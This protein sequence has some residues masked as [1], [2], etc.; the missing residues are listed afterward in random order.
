MGLMLLVG[1]AGC[2]LFWVLGGKTMLERYMVERMT[3]PW[4]VFEPPAHP[5]PLDASVSRIKDGVRICN[6]GTSR[7]KDVLVRIRTQYMENE[8]DWLAKLEDIKPSTCRDVLTSDFS[9]PDWEKIPASPN[10]NV[11]QV[12][13]LATVSGRGYMKQGLDSAGRP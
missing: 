13:V 4:A 5:L 2:V 3:N 11:A 9:S 6:Q 10:L 12:E 7:W 8:Y 1:L